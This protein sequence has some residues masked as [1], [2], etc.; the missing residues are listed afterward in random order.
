MP[1]PMRLIATEAPKPL[2]LE[3]APEAAMACRP[4]LCSAVTLT[5]PVDRSVEPSFAIAI[6]SASTT[7]RASAPANAAS[8]LLLPAA[9]NAVAT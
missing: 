8:P 5:S 4:M 1:E 3:T 9:V 7:L 2:S 6:V